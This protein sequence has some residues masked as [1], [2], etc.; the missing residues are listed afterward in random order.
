MAEPPAPAISSAVTMGAASRRTAS[1]DADPVND[2]APSWRVSDPSWRAMTA[3]KGIATSAV[4]MIVT[5]A[6]NHA[7][8][9]NSR[10]WKGRLGSDLHDVEEEREEVAAGGERPGRREPP[11]EQS[12]GLRLVR[13]RHPSPPCRGSV[14]VPARAGWPTASG[15]GAQCRPPGPWVGE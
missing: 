12:G 2:C 6:M 7:C 13:R 5:L 8:C 15:S 3:P 11:V 9:R 1:T 14:A 4:G 10:I